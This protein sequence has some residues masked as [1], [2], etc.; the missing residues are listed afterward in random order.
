MVRGSE[1]SC[2][3]ASQLCIVSGIRRVETTA[4]T[5]SD[6][7]FC[8]AAIDM[9]ST[10]CFGKLTASV[11]RTEK[12]SIFQRCSALNQPKCRVLTEVY[13]IKQVT[14]FLW[15]GEPGTLEQHEGQLF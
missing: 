3:T 6:P 13:E 14:D 5:F 12:R 4:A 8:Q 2:T 15:D 1:E 7:T 11:I 9:H 10:C